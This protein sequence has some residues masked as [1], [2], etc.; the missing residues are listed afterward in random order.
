[1]ANNYSKM[2]CDRTIPCTQEEYQK[3]FDLLE[4]NKDANE[5]CGIGCEFDPKDKDLYLFADE[6]ADPECL[7]AEV[8][9]LVGSLLKKA[10]MRFVTLQCCFTSDRVSISSQGGQYFRITDKG[11][12]V[13]PKLLWPE[14]VAKMMEKIK[15]VIS[16]ED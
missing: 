7:P 14:D 12:L 9:E 2:S 13:T 6:Y 1:M 10:G 5:P 16:A 3:I 4:Q 15:E 11:K 8:V